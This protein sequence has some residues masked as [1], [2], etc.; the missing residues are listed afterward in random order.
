MKIKN[1]KLLV[2][3]TCLVVSIVLW[4][5]IMVVTNPTLEETYPNIPVTIRNLS[6]LENSNLVMMNQDKENLTVTV[7][8]SGLTD[9]LNKLNSRDFSAYI[10]VLGFKE[11]VTNAKV[12]VIGPGGVEIKNIKPTQ[13]AC[14]IE[15]V[16]SKVMDVTVQ[17]EG[18]QANSYYRAS[19][20][21][22]PS[23]VKITGPRSVV[24]SADLAVATVNINNATDTVVRTVPVR[25]YDDKDTEIFMS[26]P[27][28]NVELTVPIYP[29]KYVELKPTITGLPEE[30]YELVDVTVKPERV[31]ISARKD[32]LDTVTELNLEELIITG[33]Y[34]NILSS[35]EILN[36]DGLILL[37][38]E[39]TPVV[40]A[41]IE[42]VIEREFKYSSTDIQFINQDDK[43]V[44]LSQEDTEI[45]LMVEG[46]STLIN[47]LQKE[48]LILTAD[49]SETTIGI[50][51]V[52]IECLTEQQLN[53]IELS[54]NS[55]TIEIIESEGTETQTPEE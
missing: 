47:S 19:P 25:I 13:I 30:G 5:T 21:S 41:V 6:T 42:K 15:A 2:R 14:N 52:E 12:E 23:S 20:V 17:Y 35:K 27:T 9:Q 50:N 46:T 43:E 49:L 44:I 38:L 51:T 18:V 24:N 16:I 29:T 26:V 36:A 54:R 8:A 11:G 33:A 45:T 28:G 37:D 53:N 39:T 10:D 31:R 3:I 22:N 40:N 32:I 34:N 48:D 7:T 1:D 55:V 4:I